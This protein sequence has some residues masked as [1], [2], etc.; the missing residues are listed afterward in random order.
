[1]LPFSVQKPLELPPVDLSRRPVFV[2]RFS[3]IITTGEA[4]RR[5]SCSAQVTPLVCKYSFW[6]RNRPSHK[7]DIQEGI[8]SRQRYKNS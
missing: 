4:A 2:S 1:M 5:D 6:S 8:P 7:T 3:P